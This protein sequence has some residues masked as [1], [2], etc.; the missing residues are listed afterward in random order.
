[1]KLLSSIAAIL[2]VLGI[3][4]LVQASAP[5]PGLG[6]SP[7]GTSVSGL[8][9]GAFM[10]VQYQVAYSAS[11]NGAGV[12]AGGPYYC[13]ANLL[14]TY[15]GIC[16]GMVPMLPPNPNLMVAAA[17]LF[18]SNGDIDPLTNLQKDRVYV[19]SGTKDTVVN[20]SAVNA[21]VAFFKGVGVPNAN[22]VYI[23]KV[24]SGHALLTTGFGN[25]CGANEAPFISKCTVGKKAYDQPGAILAHIYGPLNPRAKTRTGQL[26]NFNQREF[27]DASTSMA[28]DAYVYVP[29]SCTKGASCK[30]HVAFH[31]CLQSEK[32][33]GDDFYGKSS[34][35]D[36]ADS[37]SMIILY[38]QVNDSQ[39]LNPNGCWDWYGYTGANYAYKS[40]PQ[41][42]AIHAMIERLTSPSSGALAVVAH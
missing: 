31:G 17:K 26:L 7:E 36:W 6:A 42:K 34:Y 15:A 25:S 37:N 10:A 1:M 21:T 20:Q 38:P 8:S 22:L 29:A 3:S 39:P 24:P 16:M 33:V 30:V 11:V 13:A 41:M 27:A 18:A 14:L 2:L 23:N 12:V 9:S 28:D 5:L 35:N 4:P 40:A 19:F 32:V